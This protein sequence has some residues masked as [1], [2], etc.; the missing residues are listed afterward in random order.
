MAESGGRVLSANSRHG[1]NELEQII[2]GRNNQRVQI[3]PLGVWSPH[4]GNVIECELAMYP[5][6]FRGHRKHTVGVT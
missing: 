5:N 1:R 3:S 4:G 6:A 2:G